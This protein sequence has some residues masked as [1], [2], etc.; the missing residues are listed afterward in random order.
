MVCLAIGPILTFTLVSISGNRG[1]DHWAAPGY[2]FAFALLGRDLASIPTGLP[3]RAR[4]WLASTAASLILLL[5]AVLALAR[6]P[7]PPV[8]WSAGKP[9]TYPLIETVSWS[10]LQG[11]LARRGLLDRPDLFIAATR[12]HEAGRADLALAGRLPVRCL[13]KDARGYGVLY[14]NAANSGQDALIV[15]ERLTEA[16][17]SA[18]YHACFDKVEQL[19][20][21]TVHQG[22]TPVAQIQLFLGKRYTP[23]GRSA[24]CKGSCIERRRQQRCP[25]IVRNAGAAP[26]LRLALCRS[27]G[28]ATGQ[29]ERVQTICLA[30]IFHA[31]A[32]PRNMGLM[33]R[34]WHT[35]ASYGIIRVP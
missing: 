35:C 28:M 18:A 20:P 22:G 25:T 6:L 30:R 12:W 27:H 13:C 21:V 31:A 8:T 9:P 34:N 33:C 24:L 29:A 15:G 1:L 23:Q 32:A 14:D 3:K 19:A 7:W 11:A 10:E 4:V 2:L 16:G 5:I 26:R 17:V